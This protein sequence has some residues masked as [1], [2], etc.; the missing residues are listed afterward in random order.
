MA[1]K[2]PWVGLP[3]SPD[4]VLAEDAPFVGA[5]NSLLRRI[6]GRSDAARARAEAAELHLEALPWPF[7]GAF[8]APLIVLGLNPAFDPDFVTEDPGVVELARRRLAGE[9]S[10]HPYW[11]LHP[12]FFGT[13]L[14]KWDRR[15]LGYL[16][17]EC[18]GDRERVAAAVLLVNFHGYPAKTFRPIPV[19]LRSQIFGFDLVQAGIARG[20]VVVQARGEFE[21]SVDWAWVRWRLFRLGFSGRVGLRMVTV[22]GIFDLCRG[23]IAELAVEAFLVEPRHPSAGLELEIIDAF[24]VPADPGEDGRVAV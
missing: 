21:W 23:E 20:A 9:E 18:D 6:G 4:Y 5:F 16:L 8:H 14:A 17:E 24:P 7:V 12:D 1:T 11:L 22:V 15:F 13:P 19:T 3:D 10:T 2:N